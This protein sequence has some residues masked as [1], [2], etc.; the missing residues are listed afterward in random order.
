MIMMQTIDG[1]KIDTIPQI[2]LS[3]HTY[4]K[5]DYVQQYFTEQ[6]FDHAPHNTLHLTRCNNSQTTPLSLLHLMDYLM[7][8]HSIYIICNTV[9]YIIHIIVHVFITKVWTKW[10]A[11]SFLFGLGVAHLSGMHCKLNNNK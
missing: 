10:I 9:F 1:D 5:M 11:G 8:I 3:L 7:L 6:G 2:E 4:I